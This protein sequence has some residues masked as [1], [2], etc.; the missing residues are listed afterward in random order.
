M[1]G[2][3]KLT[4]PKSGLIH[5]ERQILELDA[6]LNPSR[7]GPR[8]TARSTNV[9]LPRDLT[10]SDTPPSEPPT[11]AIIRSAYLRGLPVRHLNKLP[12]AL[13]RRI[14]IFLN[15][16]ATICLSVT[17]RR[18]RKLIKTERNSLSRCAKWFVMACLEQDYIDHY[19]PQ[20]SRR[21]SLR[22]RHSQH[23]VGQDSPRTGR[24]DGFKGLTCALCK[25]KHGAETWGQASSRFWTFSAQDL[26]KTKSFERIC[27]WHFGKVIFP[28]ENV[29]PSST[30]IP[31]WVS[32]M[33]DMCMH[34]GKVQMMERC[35]CLTKGSRTES[36]G[37]EC[38]ICPMKKIRVYIR[39]GTRDDFE[40][41]EWRFCREKH[42][43]MFIREKARGKSTLLISTF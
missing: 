20:A 29:I 36:Q 17:C 15:P 11:E 9:P 18:F 2:I 14:T 3:S 27:S 13:I 25:V 39:P 37:P 12:D 1:R 23:A 41:G 35:H 43:P 16:A 28:M 5:R 8:A 21:S 4:H 42:S 30:S 31:R 40:M 6:Q 38:E 34:C 32:M 7:Y 33:Q 24:L 22:H 26:F 19:P 10:S